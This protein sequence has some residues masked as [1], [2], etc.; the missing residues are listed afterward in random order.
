MPDTYTIDIGPGGFIDPPGKNKPKYKVKKSQRV[1]FNL[2]DGA[3]DTDVYFSAGSP[4]GVNPVRV[5]ASG[6]GALSLQDGSV[7]M[8]YAMETQS[9]TGSSDPTGT[10]PPPTDEGGTDTGSGDP[11]PTSTGGKAGDIEVT[12]P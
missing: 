12:P 11:D 4:F 9:P 1:Q 6:S 8:T 2:V 5:S 7:G 10:E 3:P